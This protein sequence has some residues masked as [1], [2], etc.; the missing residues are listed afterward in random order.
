[1]NSA[2]RGA[3]VCENRSRLIS[4]REYRFASFRLLYLTRMFPFA[5]REIHID[6]VEG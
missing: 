3:D 1:M 2:E 5:G 6:I 4:E